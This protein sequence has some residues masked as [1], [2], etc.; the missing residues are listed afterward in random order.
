MPAWSS[1]W[2]T[3]QPASWEMWACL[4]L[5]FVAL[6]MMLGYSGSLIA[7]GVAAL[8]MA[9]LS[10]AT[11]QLGWPLVPSW[12]AAILEYAVLATGTVILARWLIPKP[13]GKDINDY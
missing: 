13:T 6:D 4:G 3:L 12:I 2:F 10:I 11:R 1:S 8:I 9:L 7:M 5:A